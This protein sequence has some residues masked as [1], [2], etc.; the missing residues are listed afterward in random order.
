MSAP[1]VVVLGMMTKIPVAGVVWQTAQYLQGLERLGCE[2]VY[3]ESHARTPSMFM[4]SESDDGS[5]RAAAFLDRCA[6]RFDFRWAYRALHDDGA[7][8]GMAEHELRSVLADADAVINLHG[9]TDPELVPEAAGRLV[10]LETDPVQLQVELHDGVEATRSFLDAHEVFFTFGESWGRPGCLLPRTDR[11]TFWPT[12]QPVILDWWPSVPVGPEA[13]FTTVGNWRQPWRDVWLHGERYG[14]SKEQEFSK[15]LALPGRVRALT[16][17]GTPAP[18][19]ELA[20]SGAEVEDVVALNAAGWSVRDGLELSSDLDDYRSFISTSLCEF[21]SA[22][23]QN[24]RLSSGWFSDRSATYLAA[25]RPVITQATGFERV[26][27][28]GDGL[29]AFTDLDEACAAVE[30]VLAAPAAHAAA[31]REVAREYLDSDRVLTPMLDRMGLS[32]AGRARRARVVAPMGPVSRRPLQ[33]A[34]GLVEALLDAPTPSCLPLIATTTP[35]VSV[36]VVTWNHLA[37]TRWCLESLLDDPDARDVEIIVVDNGS[38]DAT[39]EYLKELAAGVPGLIVVANEDN[40]GFAPAVNQGFALARGP[41]L[42]S[43]NNDCVVPPGWTRRLAAH[44]EDPIIGMVCPRTNSAPTTAQIPTDHTNEL[45]LRR[46][47]V[48]LAEN[49]PG[50]G[51]DTDDLT[52]FCVALRAETVTQIGLLDEQFAV[53]MFEDDDYSLRIRRAGL[54]LRVAHDVLVHHHGEGSFGDLYPDGRHSA[55][56]RS[57]RSRFED[58]WGEGW[59]G[60]TRDADSAYVAMVYALRAELS[61]RIEPGTRVAMVSKGDADLL[62]MGALTVE[63]FP[64]G[65]DGGHLG[66]HP[67]DS[68][69]AIALVIAAWDRGVRCFVVPR[70]SAWWLD[71]YRDLTAQLSARFERRTDLDCGVIFEAGS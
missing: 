6:R 28:T 15:F 25:G 41:V 13:G 70:T 55:L 10:Y 42:I 8:H 22:K 67:A 16:P 35:T 40:L 43:L 44:L 58:K 39:P 33:L 26:L 50:S 7:T 46:A 71:H 31:A 59:T 17:P 47:D 68:A 62:A 1:R 64:A 63:H 19:F 4:D 45:G 3:V 51:H 52:M 65:P 56:F 66:H 54:R 5:G 38:T 69:A 57:N 24:V 61:E 48:A 11:Y 21:T 20:L 36:V 32:P 30:A 49:G 27:P 53:G 12:R 37:L 2:V 9:G 18:S 23:D 60:H 34:D 14:W 29:L